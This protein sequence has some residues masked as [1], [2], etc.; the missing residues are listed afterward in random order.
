MSESTGLRLRNLIDA[1]NAS[2]SISMISIS[3][4]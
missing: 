2:I 3:N 4:E 1:E